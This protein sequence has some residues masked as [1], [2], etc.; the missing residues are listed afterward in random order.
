MVPLNTGGGQPLVTELRALTISS[1]LFQPR[2]EFNFGFAT[3]ETVLPQT[4]LDS[5]TVT[6]QDVNR[7]FTAVYLTSDASGTVLAPATPGGLVIDPATITTRAIA[8]PSLQPVLAIGHAYQF[9]AA[10]P[11]Q[12]SGLVVNVFF[13]LF[14]NLDARAS[15]GWF[16]DLRVTAVP[17]P[18]AG[19]VVLLGLGFW[20]IRNRLER[21]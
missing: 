13:D 9:N 16:S 17:E 20:W 8:Y 14:D 10:V 5:F 21:R 1:N 12:F 19:T 7:A 3:D 2:L 11:A 18:E 15:Q 4:I 6:I